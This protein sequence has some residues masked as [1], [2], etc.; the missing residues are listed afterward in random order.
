MNLCRVTILQVRLNAHVILDIAGQYVKSELGGTLVSCNLL[1]R[2]FFKIWNI[3]HSW[4]CETSQY[5]KRWLGGA[6]V[7]CNLLLVRARSWNR[8]QLKSQP[9]FIPNFYEVC[10]FIPENIGFPSSK[11]IPMLATATNTMQWYIKAVQTRTSWDLGVFQYDSCCICLIV[12]CI[13]FLHLEHCIVAIIRH[14]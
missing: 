7:S 12:C 11:T 10:W 1:K 2:S 8:A 13:C 9:I 6:L 14:N 3:D 5:V 4:S